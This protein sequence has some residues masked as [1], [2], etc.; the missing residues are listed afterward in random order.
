MSA[1]LRL[2]V[3]GLSEGNG[4]PYSWSAIFNGYEPQAMEACGFASIPRYLEL[5]SWPDAEIA[6]A[7]VTHVWTQDQALSRHIATASRIPQVADRFT[8]MLGRVDGLLLA[9]DD[10]Q[11]HLAFAGPY[12]DAGVP[13]YVDKPIS[14]TVREAQALFARQ[15]YPGQ[16]FTCSALRY[17]REL[18]LSDEARKEI[19][20]ICHIHATAPKDWDRYAVHV[21]E[22]MLAMAGGTGAP[23]RTQAW[24]EGDRTILNLGWEAGLQATVATL[25]ACASPM[26]LRVHGRAG[27]RELI[28]SDTFGAFRAALY[29]F[30]QGILHRDV[31]AQP[32]RVLEIVSIIEAGRR[33]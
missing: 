7:K 19:G 25:G 29:D 20:A 22:P 18:S 33:T 27:W 24:R 26:A 32:A 13:V 30:V 16:L 8:D 21:V 28:F 10:A 17:A 15:R 1:R 4:H 12:L 3:I 2:G 14:L 23:V 11:N 9:R 6:E 31:R 5:Q